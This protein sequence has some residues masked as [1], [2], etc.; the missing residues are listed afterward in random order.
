MRKLGAALG[1]EAMSLYNHVENKDDLFDAL[2]ELLYQ[3]V[4]AHYDRAAPTWQDRAR[5]MAFAYWQVAQEHPNAFSIIAEHPASSPSGVL[6]L[7]DCVKLF[8]D[9]GFDPRAAHLVFHAA[10]A[11]LVGTINQE[12]I[13]M[14]ELMAGKGFDRGDLAPDLAFLADF[15]DACLATTPEERFAAGLEVLL[16]GIE[17]QL[18]RSASSPRA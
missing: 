9:A 1:V 16:A 3:R 18:T 7:A 14:K 15:K 8:V 6:V 4:L 13:L 2:S 12:Q 17:T 5:S 10:G 11:W